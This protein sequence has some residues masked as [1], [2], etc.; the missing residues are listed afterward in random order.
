LESRSDAHDRQAVLVGEDE[1]GLGRLIARVLTEEGY[2]APLES[3]GDG[4]LA[5]ALQDAPAVV[6]LDVALP[7]L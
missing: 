4:G 6:V 5:G 3:R 7:V 1:I 2:D